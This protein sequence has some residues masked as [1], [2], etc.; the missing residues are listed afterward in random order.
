MKTQAV[1]E[2]EQGPMAYGDKD[3]I[4]KGGQFHIVEYS[5]G[6]IRAYFKPLG[7]KSF[8]MG[9]RHISYL[10]EI[11]TVSYDSVKAAK[12]DCQEFFNR[13]GSEANEGKTL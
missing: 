5:S 7:W 9:V 2:F 4:S 10:G 8:G 1:I 3:W 13:F 12:S 11:K 6:S